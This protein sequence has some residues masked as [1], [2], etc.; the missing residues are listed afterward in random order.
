[1][2]LELVSSRTH[3]SFLLIILECDEYYYGEN[4]ETPCDCQIGSDY[5]HPVAGCIC[6]AGWTGPQ[7]GEDK[8]ECDSEVNP[9]QG[10]YCEFILLYFGLRN[11]IMHLRT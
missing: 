1:M 6:L 2:L 4:C 9:C 5:C 10:K 11:C 7:C 8:N 3:P